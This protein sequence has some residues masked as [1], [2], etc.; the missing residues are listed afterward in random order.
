MEEKS[1]KKFSWQTG[2]L[3][4]TGSLIFSFCL[5]IGIGIF[6]IGSI[7]QGIGGFLGENHNFALNPLYSY[8][9]DV[10]NNYA[11]GT[12]EIAIIEIHDVISN[13][14]TINFIKKT[15]RDIGEN[16]NIIGV[17]LSLDTP[18]GEVT[19]TDEIYKIINELRAKNKLVISCMRSVATSG[20]YYLAAG[21]D[22]IIA[23][24]YT[25]TGSI[26]VIF[27]TINVHDLITKHG[28]KAVT[29]KSGIAKNTLDP[30][31]PISK[32][33]KIIFQNLID[34]AYK[35]FAKVVSKGRNIKYKKF[36]EKKS[37]YS[38][39]QIF[40]GE[41]ALKL[42]LV[43]QLGYLDDAVKKIKELKKHEDVKVYYCRPYK[44][45]RDYFDDITLGGQKNLFNK[46]AKYSENLQSGRLYYQAVE[47]R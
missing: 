5:L 6:F 32:K 30:F 25:I 22:Y 47:L 13:G 29:I 41:Q 8:S 15:L 39:A 11:H 1:E 36:F 20:G 27:N 12:K 21:T 28:V 34:E 4:F 19:A 43:D 7:V 17:I 16:E 31:H 18:G 38:S 33:G 2:C 45:L 37:P 9:Q 24:K 14:E 10:F 40:S 35:G 3:L 23:N 26:G 42:N 46:I 44:S